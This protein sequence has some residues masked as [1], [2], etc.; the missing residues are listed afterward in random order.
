M[1]RYDG[2]KLV[3]STLIRT[4][5]P[6]FCIALVPS[7]KAVECS[8]SAQIAETYQLDLPAFLLRTHIRVLASNANP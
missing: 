1:Y 8:L 7:C 2:T 4:T 5:E 6:F 3:Y